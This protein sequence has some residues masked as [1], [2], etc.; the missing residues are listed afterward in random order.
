[1][2]GN[3]LITKDNVNEEVAK[4]LD[5][6]Y[7]KVHGQI[8]LYPMLKMFRPSQNLDDAWFIVN[9]LESLGIALQSYHT[10]VN[11]KIIGMEV[12]FY[13][14]SFTGSIDTVIEFDECS[15]MALCK[16]GIKMLNNLKKERLIKQ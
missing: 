2:K 7:E 9:K 12:Q 14:C 16:A 15:R 1:M 5:I 3:K 8:Y 6:K 13:D 4:A 10:V 11:D